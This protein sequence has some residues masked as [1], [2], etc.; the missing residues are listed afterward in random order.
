MISFLNYLDE[1]T[2]TLTVP[3]PTVGNCPSL[4]RLDVV[5][6]LRDQYIADLA[7]MDQ[8]DACFFCGYAEVVSRRLH[9]NA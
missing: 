2:R 7:E 3:K 8:H 5:Q 6:A 1:P 4:A 9:G